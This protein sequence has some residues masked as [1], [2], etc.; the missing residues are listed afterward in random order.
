LNRQ[1]T[2]NRFGG[3]GEVVTT[4]LLEG[5]LFQGKGRVFAHTVLK[6]GCSIGLHKHE[7]DFETYYILTGE[8]M[9]NDNGTLVPVKAGDVLY[10]ADGESHGLENTGTTD[11]EY[12]ALILYS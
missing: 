7:G 1:V 3:K 8:G 6:P 5:D 10:T 9:Y 12:I 11:L 2:A 4:H